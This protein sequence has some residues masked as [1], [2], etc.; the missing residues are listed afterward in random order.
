[1]FLKCNLIPFPQKK[2]AV[3][4]PKTRSDARHRIGSPLSNMLDDRSK[5]LGDRMEDDG[6]RSESWESLRAKFVYE[7]L[8]LNN[9]SHIEES[10]FHDPVNLDNLYVKPCSVFSA[11]SCRQVCNTEDDHF[12]PH[13]A[14]NTLGLGFSECR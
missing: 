3:K 12:S 10:S 11:D 5:Y 9:N 2:K 13:C 1:M 4:T 6:L 7:K 14:L 8:M